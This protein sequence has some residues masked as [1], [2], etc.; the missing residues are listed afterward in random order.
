MLKLPSDYNVVQLYGASMEKLEVMMEYCDMGSFRSEIEK[1]YHNN[2]TIKTKLLHDCLIQ[3]SRGMV[4][5]H[6]NEVIHRD[7]ALRNVLWSTRGF[8][9]GSLQYCF[10]VSD[11]GMSRVVEHSSSVYNE[12]LSEMFSQTQHQTQSRLYTCRG[13][14][15]VPVRWMPPECLEQ[16]AQGKV[17]YSKEADVWSF[18]VVLWEMFCGELPYYKVRTNEQVIEQVVEHNKRLERPEYCSE[19]VWA[20][21]EECFQEANKRPHFWKLRHTLYEIWEATERREEIPICIHS[22]YC[23]TLREQKQGDGDYQTQQQYLEK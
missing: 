23:P 22:E 16:L 2:T 10:K 4:H 14:E 8:W 6:S 3:V 15:G 12:E 20:V 21:A 11:F 7:L 18:G 17:R 5:L 1:H 9:D 19:E 13:T